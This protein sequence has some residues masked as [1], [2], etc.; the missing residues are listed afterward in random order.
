LKDLFH[1][2]LLI[3]AYVLNPPVKE[4]VLNDWMTRLV[5]AVGMRMV[6]APRSYFVAD[7]GNEGL[8]GSCNIATSHCAIH[9]WSEEKPAR[10]EMDLYS[11]SCFQAET[12]LGMLAEWGL[13]AH[14][15]WMVDRNGPEFKLVKVE[16]KGKPCPSAHSSIE[17]TCTSTPQP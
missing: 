14:H 17:T 11:C 3:R 15:F 4:E 13:V 12:I 9:I 10:I 16:T 8:T 7:P 6:I 1:Q 2:H 5:A